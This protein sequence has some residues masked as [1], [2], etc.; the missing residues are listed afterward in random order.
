MP[1]DKIYQ[2]AIESTTKTVSMGNNGH[3]AVSFVSATAADSMDLVP[4]VPVLVG[5][6]TW[7]LQTRMPAELPSEVIRFCQ[8]DSPVSKNQLAP[9]L[10]SDCLAIGYGRQLPLASAAKQ[11]SISRSAQA[12]TTGL[13]EFL[14][15]ALPLGF[16]VHASSF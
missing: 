10:H 9:S 12:L 4:F 6:P 16:I 11:Y 5:R 8:C 13:A 3:D 1:A 2:I 14:S 7:P 15:H